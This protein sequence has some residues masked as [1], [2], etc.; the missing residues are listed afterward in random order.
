MPMSASEVALRRRIDELHLASPFAGTRML[1]GLLPRDGHAIGRQYVA[2]LVRRMGIE[3]V[4]RNTS[5]R[6]QH[7]AHGVNF[8]CCAIWRSTPEPRLGGGCQC[9]MQ[10]RLEKRPTTP[11]GCRPAAGMLPRSG[12]ETGRWRHVPPTGITASF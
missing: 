4:Y 12:K 7:P 10:P 5:Q 2:T 6:H 1:R 8:Y 3:A 11:A 9:A